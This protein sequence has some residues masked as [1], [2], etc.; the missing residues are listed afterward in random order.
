MGVTFAVRGFEPVDE[1]KNERINYRTP[2]NI[3]LAAGGAAL[4]AGIVMIAVDVGKRKKARAKS[5]SSG[6]KTRV[7]P[8]GLGVA[9]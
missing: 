6:A 3:V 1:F 8:H 2:G 4:I 7:Q 5:Q 9:F